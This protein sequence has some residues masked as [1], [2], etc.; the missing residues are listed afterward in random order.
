LGF[1]QKTW[2]EISIHHMVSEFLRAERYKF[3]ENQEALSLIDSANVT[4]PAENHHRLRLLYFIRCALFTEIPPDTRW[5]EVDP[6]T[7]DDFPAL[8]VI[9]RLG[10]DDPSGRDRNELAETAIRKPQTLRED[11]QNDAKVILWGHDNDGPFTILEG[12]HRL[13]AYAGTMATQALSIPAIVGL[14]S[15][16]CLW[17]FADPG[18]VIA[19]DLWNGQRWG[20][21]PHLPK[22]FG[23][24][25]E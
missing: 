2:I 4:D 9:A 15:S 8:H 18:F 21:I 7:R 14:S 22:N 19:N 1:A 23:A 24:E 3:A 12:N 25:R 6:L 20:V 10:W 17:H 13:T 5:F 11:F 16:Y